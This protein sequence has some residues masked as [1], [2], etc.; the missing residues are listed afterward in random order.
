MASATGSESTSELAELSLVE[1]QA[2]LGNA[3]AAYVRDGYTVVSTWDASAKLTKASRV[4]MLVFW[5][6]MFFVGVGWVILWLLLR[7]DR[8][9]F[10]TVDGNGQVTTR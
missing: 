8:S 4:P 7:R 3:V 6:L 2:I 10:I 1:R 9:L 5:P